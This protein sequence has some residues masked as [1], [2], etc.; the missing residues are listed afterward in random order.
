MQT[1]PFRFAKIHVCHPPRWPAGRGSIFSEFKS[2]PVKP[3]TWLVN[4]NMDPD[5]HRDDALW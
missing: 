3:E 2:S 5:I 1:K 4:P